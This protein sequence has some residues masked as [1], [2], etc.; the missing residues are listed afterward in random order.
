MEQ[1]YAGGSTPGQ[2]GAAP[3]SAGGS[4]GVSGT[5]QSGAEALGR[6]LDQAQQTAEQ[7]TN[8][9]HGE[10]APVVEQAQQ[11][12]GQVADQ[13]RQQAANRVE[14]Q[15]DQ[16]INVLAM[17]A[18]AVRQTSQELRGQEQPMLADC[19][20]RTAQS[21]EQMANYLRARDVGALLDDTQSF[22]RRNPALFL[23]GSFALGLLAA[24]FFKSSAPPRPAAY[25]YA[26]AQSPN[27]IHP[28]ATQLYGQATA[29]MPHGPRS[30]AET[31]PPVPPTQTAPPSGPGLSAKATQPPSFELSAMDRAEGG[32]ER[33]QRPAPPAGIGQGGGTDSR[34]G[35]GRQA[36][37]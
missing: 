10:A 26:A 12:A 34:T 25:G 3:G 33:T 5:A 37:S 36:G 31:R 7:V 23:G 17:L 16:A 21:V 1:R 22:A 9:I 6:V 27:R 30:S 14:S 29:A 8:R 18:Q 28:Y 35:D 32:A 2:G 11:A 24:R 19:V 20:D 4:S 13:A 15:K